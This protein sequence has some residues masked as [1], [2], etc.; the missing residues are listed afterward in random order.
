[1]LAHDSSRPS[2]AVR[3]KWKC[4]SRSAQNTALSYDELSSVADLSAKLALSE[5]SIERLSHRA[6][7]FS[8]KLLLRR[9][10][11]LR[12]LGRFMLDPSMAWIDTID[13][14][15]YDQAQFTRY[16]QRFMGM[17]PRDY[18]ARPT[19]ILGAAAVARA[20]AAGAAVQGLHQ[21]G[22]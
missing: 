2:P 20:A 10:R 14:H 3:T 18:A 13:H 15:Y 17:S 19:P 4:R 9:Q 5:R 16:F 6:F 8:P 22:G 12:S 21:P 1:M 7:G 11:F